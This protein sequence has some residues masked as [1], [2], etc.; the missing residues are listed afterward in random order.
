[1]ENFLNPISIN[2]KGKAIYVV[3][4]HDADKD[5][6]M[7][8]YNIL[9]LTLDSKNDQED[10]QGYLPLDIPGEVSL[11][12]MNILRVSRDIPAGD[13][14]E[15]IT[16]QKYV[17]LVRCYQNS[18]F[19][20]RYLMVEAPN[21]NIKGSSRYELQPAWEVRFQRSQKPDTPLDSKDTQSYMSLERKNFVEPVIELPFD[22]QQ[23]DLSTGYFNVQLV[24]TSNQDELRWQFILGN[25]ADGKLYT[26][27]IKRNEQG[28]FYFNEN[29]VSSD[30][31]TILPDKK[32]Q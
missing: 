32:I 11:A 16:D 19:I 3:S 6:Y 8:S 17:Y 14:I 30:N 23:I 13:K 20:N 24:P 18:L 21:P 29:Q 4:S 31:K 12:G 15:V 27:S 10:W 28:W 22:A 5:Q 26:Y 1:M 7:Y 2:H 9:N 25:I